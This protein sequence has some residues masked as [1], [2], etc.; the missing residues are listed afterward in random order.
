VRPSL[1][2]RALVKPIQCPQASGFDC[3]EVDHFGA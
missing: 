2:I 3:G 1:T